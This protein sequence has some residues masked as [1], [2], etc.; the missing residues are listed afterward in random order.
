MRI[1]AQQV[2]ANELFD[3]HVSSGSDSAV[4]KAV[5]TTIHNLIKDPTHIPDGGEVD[6]LRK[7]LDPNGAR[8]LV[9]VEALYGQQPVRSTS[10]SLLGEDHNNQEDHIRALAFIAA[11][12]Q[13]KILPTVVVFER[14]MNYPSPQN[15]IIV[16]ETNL[17]TAYGVDFGFAL[18][19]KQRS[20]VIAGYLVLIAA[21]GDQMDINKFLLFFGANHKD[22]LDQYQYF[23]RHTA[24]YLLKE[25]RFLY[26]IESFA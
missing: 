15:V 4:A 6:P 10:L 5:L 9:E 23:A 12:N 13:G 16:R 17:T 22:M 20:M 1:I 19:A 11:I 2:Y 24:D 14:G 21:S 3:N 26:F 7:N 25:I 18:T 8:A